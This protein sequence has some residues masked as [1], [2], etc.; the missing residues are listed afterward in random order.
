MSFDI[1]PGPTVF[2]A[3]GPSGT[4]TEARIINGKVE[5]AGREYITPEALADLLGVTTRTL[6][7]WD[8][9]RIGPPK[10]KVGRTVLFDLAKLPESLAS[11]ETAP[12]RL[13]GRHR[14]GVRHG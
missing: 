6:A 11:R 1:N 2:D 12:V 7:R 10:I 5:I 3:G 13:S 4:D 14:G 8:A 9:A